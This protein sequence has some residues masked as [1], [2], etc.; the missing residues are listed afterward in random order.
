MPVDTSIAMG[1][2]PVQFDNPVDSYH[3]VM[4]LKNI[5]LQGQVQGAQ[6]QEAVRKQEEQ[7][8]LADVYRA[9]VGPDGAPNH[10]AILQGMAAVGLG[11]L[12]PGYRKTMLDTNKDQAEI[13]LKGAQTKKSEYDLQMGHLN[14]RAGALHSL[15]AKPSVTHED[16]VASLVNLA[17]D[18]AI[19]M[20]QGRQAVQQLPSDPAALRQYLMQQGL[21]VMDAAKRAEM[22]APKL[23]QVDD[24]Q[25]INMGTTN[26]LT[27]QFTPGKSF[28]QKVATPSDVLQADTSVGNNIRTNNTSVGNNIRTNNTSR[29]NNMA[30]IAE[31]ARGHDL[32][33]QSA[34]TKIEQ[35]PD[36]FV[37]VN[38]AGPK[39]P[40]S[41][42]VTDVRGVQT[43][44]KDSPV[45]KAQQQYQRLTANIADA[46]KLIPLAT[47]SGAGA[48]VDK[49]LGFTGVGTDGADA[50]GQLEVIGG[51]MTS[52]I[53]R[54]EGPQSDKDTEQY[55]LMAAQVGNRTVPAS[56]RLKA[57]ETLEKLQKDYRHLNQGPTAKDSIIRIEKQPGAKPRPPLST[58]GG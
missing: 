48:L 12:I 4:A 39:G 50:A 53:P 33:F 54:M 31:V 2:R 41:T 20:D 29:A 22:M 56:V 11:H 32:T 9:N 52:N 21:Q 45:W 3:K 37:I 35:T 14:A 27:G 40:T 46:K 10:P 24:G 47:S 16:V 5:G 23:T 6:V 25:R 8:K 51:W 42:P 1:G 34:N 57:L 55:K 19:T 38:T 26:M 15:L 28:I 43:Q 30:T 13:D 7:L 44:Q 18:G 17:N 49:G 58:F 36:G